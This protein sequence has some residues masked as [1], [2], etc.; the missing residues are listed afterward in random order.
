[1]GCGR[2]RVRGYPGGEEALGFGEGEVGGV[3]GCG[4]FVGADC[5]GC[6]RRHA[7]EGGGGQSYLPATLA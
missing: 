7:G 2:L 4:S 6:G 1:M 3:E 5:G